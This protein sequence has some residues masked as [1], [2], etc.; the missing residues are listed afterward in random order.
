MF[1]FNRNERKSESF[2]IL[3][4]SGGGDQKE[5]LGGNGLILFCMIF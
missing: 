1:S 2:A 3:M 4:F 5:V